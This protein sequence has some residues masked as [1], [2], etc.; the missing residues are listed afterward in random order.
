MQGKHHLGFGIITA[1]ATMAVANAF[2]GGE[3][4]DVFIVLAGLGALLPDIDMPTST[5][6]KIFF[7][8]PLALLINKLVG[9][10]TLTHDPV[11][12]AVFAMLTIY[13][14]PFLMG[15]W[16]GYF[17]HLFL[18]GLTVGGLPLFFIKRTSHLLP[19]RI[20][21]YSTS[22]AATGITAL[23]TFLYCG[24]SYFIIQN[25]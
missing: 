14:F 3:D 10:R 6:G 7:L 1:T 12:A 4:A 5:I 8:H 13:R 18:D 19:R 17:S 22:Q 15:L 9:H 2:G 23:M 24:G 20:K 25:I 16:F 11:L 21:L